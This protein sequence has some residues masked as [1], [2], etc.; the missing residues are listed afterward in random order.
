MLSW[1]CFPFFC[2]ITYNHY[3]GTRADKK[4]LHN[5]SI[6]TLLQY[7]QKTKDIPLCQFP[8]LTTTSLL[9]YENIKSF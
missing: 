4:N 8:P 9:H 3:K 1:L 7:E 2:K 5:E 6:L